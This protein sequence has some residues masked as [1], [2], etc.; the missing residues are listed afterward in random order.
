M[1]FFAYA[2]LKPELQE[3]SRP[4]G[5]LAE[6]I[7]ETLPDNAERTTALRKLLEAKDCSVR[8]LLYRDDVEQVPAQ[9]RDYKK[10]GDDDGYK[11]L[12]PPEENKNG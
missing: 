11:D 6:W 1:Q 4:F 2:H 3:I 8:A 7:T 9:R 10:T 5:E 12:G